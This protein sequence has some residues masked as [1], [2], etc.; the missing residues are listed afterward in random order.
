[1]SRIR[2]ALK[3][4][5]EER[6]VHAAGQATE[7]LIDNLGTEVSAEARPIT[8]L[9]PAQ[10]ER[11]TSELGGS[12]EFDS[13]VSKCV[14]TQFHIEPRYSVFA[15]EKND[16]GGAERFRTL[17]SRLFQIAAAEPLRTVLISS[18]VPQEGKTF[19]ASNLAQ[20]IVRQAGRKVLL[21]DSDLRASRLHHTLGTHGQP[22]LSDYLS[23]EADLTKVMQVGAERN[24]C[25]I[26][27]GR[28]MPNPS[29]LLNSERMKS[30]LKRTA[31]LFDW[32]ILDSPPVI[33]VHDASSLA[34]LCD[35][36]IFVVRA[37]YTDF[38][39]AQKAAAEFQEK[40]VLG[41]VLNRVNRKESYG[42][43]YY[44][45]PNEKAD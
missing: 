41:V 5:A 10:S 32:V 27:G 6:S 19:V 1:M 36:M 43:Y 14:K 4:A 13:L 44:G 7:D 38:E 28:V 21:I 39:L 40:R 22:G 11:A 3:R 26:P 8:Q 45:Y 18:T 29:E 30:M 20:S 9:P 33:A 23:G 34:D 31:E 37:G 24:L 12:T 16:R 17:R 2:D 35:G 15:N 42:E 25:F